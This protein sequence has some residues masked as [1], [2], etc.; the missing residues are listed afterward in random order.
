MH[1]TMFHWE[2]KTRRLRS[3]ALDRSM[4]AGDFGIGL[5][6]LGARLIRVNQ[7]P[8]DRS[9][10]LK[11]GRVLNPILDAKKAEATLCDGAYHAFRDQNL[12]NKMEHGSIIRRKMSLVWYPYWLMWVGTRRIVVDGACR[13]VIGSPGRLKSPKD[14]IR[15]HS[16]IPSLIAAVCPNCGGDFSIDGFEA[17]YYCRYC[18]ECWRPEGRRLVGQEILFVRC[19]AGDAKATHHL[20]V[21]RMQTSLK[22]PTSV[23]SD[24]KAFRKLIPGWSYAAVRQDPKKPFFV[25]VPAWGNRL[26]PRMSAFAQRWTREQPDIQFEKRKFIRVF[27]ALYGPREAEELA[28]ITLLGVAHKCKPE[29]FLNAELNVSRCELLLV[30]SR[31]GS[32]EWIESVMETAIPYFEMAERE[33]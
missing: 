9:E 11:H 7:H 15:I 30:P 23:F 18:Q 3:K 16:D 25:Y 22:N 13:G 6:S 19:P 2:S 1:G 17:L 32:P 20:P 8:Y 27:R 31:K 24:Q 4:P 12:E 21:W 26:N 29:I 33:F 14:A 10:I 28:L 5:P